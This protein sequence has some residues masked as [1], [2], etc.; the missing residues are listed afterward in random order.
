VLW[1]GGFLHPEPNWIYPSDKIVSELLFFQVPDPNYT[2]S[3][4]RNYSSDS[5]MHLRD[6][7][8]YS[9]LSVS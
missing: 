6:A 9:R 3:S 2:A 8:C 1:G 4:S 7:I 5:D